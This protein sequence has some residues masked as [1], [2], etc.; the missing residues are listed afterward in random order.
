MINLLL[1]QTINEILCICISGPK[2][3]RRKW[4]LDESGSAY[5]ETEN[6]IEQTTETIP[7]THNF[8]THEEIKEIYYYKNGVYI[9]GGEVI[10]ERESE[11]LCGYEISNKHIT[12][13]KGHIARK[14]YHKREELD[15]DVTIINLEN[16]LYDMQG[17]LLRTHSP[18]Y[19]SID[20][21][22]LLMIQTQS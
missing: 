1:S 2:T 6:L 14:T 8:L 4:R 21:K 10:I 17:N 22:P 11:K 13:I 20:Q 16:G 18:D 9:P 3:I 12:E 19:L 7:E 15:V 5:T